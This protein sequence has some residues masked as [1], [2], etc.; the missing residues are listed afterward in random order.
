MQLQNHFNLMIMLEFSA[1][2]FQ[3]CPLVY[4]SLV[5]WLVS[6]DTSDQLTVSFTDWLL[7]PSGKECLC[8]ASLP[9]LA[10]TD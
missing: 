3:I 1:T 4:E 6:T 2:A 5:N 10:G 8:S 7:L 9:G